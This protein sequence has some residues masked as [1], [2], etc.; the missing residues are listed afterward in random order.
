MLGLCFSFICMFIGIIIYLA[1]TGGMSQEQKLFLFLDTRIQRRLSYMILPLR[2]LGY[3]IAIGRYL[4]PAF[5]LLIAIHYSM[6]PI[7]LRYKKKSWMILVIP[8]ISL[9]SY[10]PTL[11]FKLVKS[12]FMLQQFLM[13]TTVFWI[14]LYVIVAIALLIYEYFKITIPYCKK[15]FRS[16]LV[17][18]LSVTMQY[19]VYCIQD[20]IQVY[21][22]YSTEYMRFDGRL[23]LNFAIGIKGEF[24]FSLLTIF[25]SLLGFWN[26]RNYT[27]VDRQ[28]DSEDVGIQRKF[29]TASMGVSVFVHSIK[30]QLLS[31]R[32]ICKKIS[33]ELEQ[34][35][36][37]LQ[38]LREY[39]DRLNCVNESMLE[40]MEELYRSI[41]SNY[42]LLSPVN[43]DQIVAN[44]LERFHNKYPDIP[45]ELTLET[46]DSVLADINHLSE[47]LYNLLTNAH[48]AIV[49]AGREQEN[50]EI[51]VHG[52]RLYVGF[53]IRDNGIGIA[54]QEQHK[55]FDPF[56]TSKNTNY[57]WG[58][59]L[60]YVRQIVKSH[61]GLLKLESRV[62]NG[63]SFFVMIPRYE[64]R[65]HKMKEGSHYENHGGR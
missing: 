54:K 51:R 32:I 49:Q 34:D 59:G 10:Y 6:I 4:F 60:Y 5:L 65:N 40:R 31:N 57:N 12:R 8:L 29:D 13:K 3:M 55:I 63:T 43:A 19:M 16:I 45:V 39:S 21:Q 36:P 24:V 9:I 64:P 17:F 47:A 28:E 44:T 20:P 22:M 30:N 38:L 35:P 41:K 52:E 42:I 2:Q 7:V 61:F 33:R 15:Q 25:F 48:E 14:Y 50:L 18:I 53:E 56:Y 58:M 37:N 11:F 62:E 46:N 23:Y 26:L 27:V 1:K